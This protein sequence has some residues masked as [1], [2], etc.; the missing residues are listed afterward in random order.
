MGPLTTDHSWRRHG[1]LVQDLNSFRLAATYMRTSNG[2]ELLQRDRL[3][4]HGS[5]LI[6]EHV[7]LREAGIE[8]GEYELRVSP[9][10]V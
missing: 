2:A 5:G 6:P 3:V 1:L 10:D 4:V 8:D 7:R 9:D